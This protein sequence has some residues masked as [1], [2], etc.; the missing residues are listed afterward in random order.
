MTCAAKCRKIFTSSVL[1]IITSFKFVKL[2]HCEGLI[3][4]A[5][6]TQQRDFLC[7]WSSPWLKKQANANLSRPRSMLKM[8]LSASCS[9]EELWNICRVWF[10]FWFFF[11][12]LSCLSTSR[13][14]T[15]SPSSCLFKDP[16]DCT[17]ILALPHWRF[18]QS[19]RF[20]ALSSKPPAVKSRNILIAE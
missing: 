19:P 15:D 18:E 2:K 8:T 11:Y 5:V 14:W 20:R 4:W 10:F 17:C 9:W 13:I 1:N 12:K 3:F 16:R 6:A 7:M